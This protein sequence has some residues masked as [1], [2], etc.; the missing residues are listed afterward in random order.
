MVVLCIFLSHLH[1]HEKTAFPLQ[2]RP[3]T[4]NRPRHS[5]LTPTSHIPL[6]V[7]ADNNKADPSVDAR[8][9]VPPNPPNPPEPP[10]SHVSLP[11]SQIDIIFIH[12]R[13]IGKQHLSICR[14][15][16]P[17]RKSPGGKHKRRHRFTTGGEHDMT[18]IFS[19][20]SL[21]T[22]KH[23][24]R[25]GRMVAGSVCLKAFDKEVRGWVGGRAG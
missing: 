11:S 5:I 1:S 23:T 9:P 10:S 12:L 19:V 20:G 17:S 18:H 3:A 13:E 14:V 6:P 4:A 8:L 15:T 16:P 21:L 22:W 25:A 24:S 7:C 2:L